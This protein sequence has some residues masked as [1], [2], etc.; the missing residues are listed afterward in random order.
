MYIRKYTMADDDNSDDKGDAK[1]DP[2][3]D[4]KAD[5]P[6][7]TDVATNTIPDD[8]IVVTKAEFANMQKT[9]IDLQKQSDDAEKAKV[10]AERDAVY[11]ELLI[12]NPKLA[13]IHVEASKEVLEGALSAAKEIKTGFQ[14]LKGNNKD[15][16]KADY[17]NHDSINYDFVKKEFI[18][19]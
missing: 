1:Q 14:S 15:P 13:K 16:K 2:K 11:N 8:S 5:P 19:T 7:K 4:P 3:I 10:K 18:F 6:V 12:V 9:M 17:S